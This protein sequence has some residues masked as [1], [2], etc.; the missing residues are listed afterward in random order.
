M[1]EQQRASQSYLAF[2]IDR[3]CDAEGTPLP[4]GVPERIAYR[5][6]QQAPVVLSA[7]MESA[8]GKVT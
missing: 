6:I 5:I 2:L 3:A 4:Q 1:T 7:L 8:E